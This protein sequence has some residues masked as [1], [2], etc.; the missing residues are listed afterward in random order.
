MGSEHCNNA[1]TSI[2]SLEKRRC[3]RQLRTATFLS[4]TIPSSPEADN[5][6]VTPSESVKG[7]PLR[8][9]TGIRA[10]LHPTTI[11]AIADALRFRASKKR[12]EQGSEMHFKVTDVVKP[13]DVALTA[14]QIAS[15]AI[16]NRQVASRDDSTMKLTVA[17]EQTIAGRIMGVIMRLDDLEEELFER[18]SEAEWVAQYDEWGTFGVVVNEGDNKSAV[19]EKIA[20]DP[21]FCLNRA[22]CML[23][24][25]LQEVE[26][27]QLQ[28]INETVPDNSIID[29][30]DADRLDVVLQTD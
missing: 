1:F 10:S 26:I 25:F 19:D 22:E 14:G 6:N 24:I 20:Q 29:F 3:T 21:L 2:I 9:S 17:E 13:I 11:N 27:P 28:R 5:N 12:D 23:A 18:V 7:D 16:A 8:G 15:T 4:M 30:L